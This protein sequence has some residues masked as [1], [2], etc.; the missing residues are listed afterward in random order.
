MIV[1]FCRNRV[2]DYTTWKRIFDANLG[3]A[4][5]SGLELRQ[6]WRELDDDANVYFVFHVK[7]VEPARA[8]LTL[9]KSEEAGRAA[10]VLD[11]EY[12]FLF[13]EFGAK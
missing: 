1:L 8:F 7:D 10:G 12:H 11:G 13:D 5:D 4:R 6:L 3:A 9:P 2:K